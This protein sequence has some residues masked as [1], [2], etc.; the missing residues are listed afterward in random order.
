[1]VAISGSSRMRMSSFSF[2]FPF[3][4]SFDQ[5]STSLTR[6]SPL[7]VNQSLKIKALRFTTL[8]TSLQFAPKTI[9]LF[10]NQPSVDFDS[11]DPAQELI[12]DEEQAKGL[13]AVELR[14]VKYQRVNHLS[15]RPPFSRLSQK[16]LREETGD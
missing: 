1:V 2:T 11:S 12:L 13:K 15:V 3:V 14:Y 9:R 6:P 10:V 16:Y 7:Q 5:L 8:P 4:F